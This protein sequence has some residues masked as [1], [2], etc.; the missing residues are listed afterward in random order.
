LAGE[1]GADPFADLKPG[2]EE[3]EEKPGKEETAA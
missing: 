1:I 2:K 3:D